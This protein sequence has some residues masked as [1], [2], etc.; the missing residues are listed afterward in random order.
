MSTK[1]T[2]AHVL[3][4]FHFYHECLDEE[5]VYL[6]IDNA[7][8]EANQNS[9]MLQIPLAIWETIRFYGG[10]KLKYR[11]WTDEQLLTQVE[12]EVDERIAKYETQPDKK[13]AEGLLIIGAFVYGFDINDRNAMIERAMDWMKRER[14]MHN[15]IGDE[16][17]EYRKEN[18]F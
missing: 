12:K 7:E 5:N 8:F 9:V 2:I 16:I 13:I 4:K 6:E 18:E 10:A 15:R 11:N 3:D 17:D 14:D 1:C